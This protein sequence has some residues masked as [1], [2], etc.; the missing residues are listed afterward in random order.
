[1]RLRRFFQ[2]PRRSKLK[3]LRENTR[4]S[5]GCQAGGTN[6]LGTVFKIGRDGTGYRILHHFAA[7]ADGSAPASTLLLANDGLLYGTTP[8]G[9]TNNSGVVF[10]LSLNATIYQVV[11]TFTTNNLEPSLSFSGLIQGADGGAQARA[12][13]TTWVPCS[14]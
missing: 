12:A 3:I 4:C 7:N 10:R 5:T 2:S 1:M 9:G 11:H 13:P 6:N 8:T 14:A